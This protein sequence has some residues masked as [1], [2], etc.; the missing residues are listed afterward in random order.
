MEQKYKPFIFPLFLL[1]I[2]GVLTAFKLHGSS[3]GMYNIYFYG[4]GY[5]DPDLLYGQPRAIRSDE[6]LVLTPWTVSQAQIH[7]ASNNNLY[8]AGQNLN[9]TDAPIANWTI[10]FRPQNWGFLLFPIEYA[11]SFKLK[12]RVNLEVLF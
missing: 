1:L 3:I 5:R 8:L 2:V 9:F 10:A 6:W 4:R 11:F 7:Y 12:F